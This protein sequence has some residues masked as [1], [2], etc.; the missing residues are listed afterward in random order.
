MPAAR[1]QLFADCLW[2]GERAMVHVLY[3][4]SMQ[5]WTTGGGPARQ[6]KLVLR[7]G[8]AA[9]ENT[10]ELDGVKQS[11]GIEVSH[12]TKVAANTIY[13]AHTLALKKARLGRARADVCKRV[14]GGG[15]A[16]QY[17]RRTMSL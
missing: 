15:R 17:V 6:I 12:P 11:M 4:A 2:R 10:H 14:F 13:Q 5:V 3:A 7:S 16:V 1:L 8:L 9:L